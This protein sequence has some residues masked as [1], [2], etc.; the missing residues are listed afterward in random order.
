MH[1][2]F[3]LPADISGLANLPPSIRTVDLSHIGH[4][5]MS[6]AIAGLAL[7]PKLE[8]VKFRHCQ[9]LVGNMGDDMRS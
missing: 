7:Q 8:R 3:I 1:C 9:P 6:Q 4:V 5:F 2:P